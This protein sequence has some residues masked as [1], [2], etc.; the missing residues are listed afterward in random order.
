MI[1]EEEVPVG[2]PEWLTTYG[3][4]MSLLLTFFVMLAS[5]SEIK[6]TATFHGVADSLQGRFGDEEGTGESDADG[7]PPR[8]SFLGGLIRRPRSLPAAARKHQAAEQLG[9]RLQSQGRLLRPGDRTT[10]GTVIYF[11]GNTTE[12]SPENQASLWQLAEFVQGKPQKIEIRAHAAPLAA[13]S[14]A[15]VDRWQQPYARAQAVMQYLVDEL[16]IEPQRIRL[17][18]AGPYEPLHLGA[19]ADPQ[20]KNPRVE[21]FLLEEL[22]SDLAGTTD[23]RNSRYNTTTK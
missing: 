8:K 18:V 5:I 4:L 3:D 9:E 7:D 14:G 10:A 20:Q 23:E 12:L 17:S 16:A 15:P 1:R 19:A 6:D 2:A 11:H 22:A 21:I 13:V